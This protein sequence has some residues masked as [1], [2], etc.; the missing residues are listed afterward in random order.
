MPYD[1]HLQR[2]EDQC[3]LTTYSIRTSRCYFRVFITNTSSKPVTLYPVY[4]HVR[5]RKTVVS[6]ITVQPQQEGEV[7]LTLNKF[8]DPAEDTMLIHDGNGST[9][10]ELRFRGVPERDVYLPAEDYQDAFSDDPYYSADEG[11]PTPPPRTPVSGLAIVPY[12]SYRAEVRR[13]NAYD[14]A[15]MLG[16]TSAR[17]ER[18]HA[19]L[20]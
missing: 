12:R 3:D 18:M 4:V 20:G 19:L 8:Q 1:E 13:K 16:E 11:P 10:L 7:N 2:R 14:P 15:L 6:P 5:G 9:L 17:F